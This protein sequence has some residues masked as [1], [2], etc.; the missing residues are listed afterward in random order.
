MS[1]LACP[2]GSAPHGLPLEITEYRGISRISPTVLE[3]HLEVR[4]AE[5]SL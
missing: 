4:G 2:F 3:R 1:K 5:Y